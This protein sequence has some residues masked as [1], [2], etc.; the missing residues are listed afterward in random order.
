M[1]PALPG[2]QR[3]RS[4]IRL[5]SLNVGT[6]RGRGVEV[7]EMMQRRSL[8]VLCVQETRWKGDRARM[9]VGGYKLGGTDSYGMGGDIEANG[10]CYVGIWTTNGK[11]WGR[12]AGIQG[13][14]G[15]DDGNG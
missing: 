14:T 12:E 7:V 11:D 2:G 10:V 9:L 4:E 6:M 15:E 3:F 5:G 1:G 13:C 8:E